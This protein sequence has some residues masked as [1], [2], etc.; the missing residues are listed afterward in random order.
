MQPKPEPVG[1]GQELVGG[2][3]EDGCDSQEDQAQRDD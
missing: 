2:N 1:A 3:R